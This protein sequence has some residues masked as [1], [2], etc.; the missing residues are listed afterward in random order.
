MSLNVKDMMKPTEIR[1]KGIY[2]FDGLYKLIR[3]WLD[4]RRYDYMEKRYK[5]K[6]STPFGN[7]VEIEMEPELK[8]TEFIK[9]HIYIASHF[10]DVK[11]FEAE[12]DG[13]KKLVTDGKFFMN[14][15]GWI[16]FDYTGKF[17]DKPFSK[18]LLKFLVEKVL[19]RY[20]EFKYYDRL[21]YDVYDLQAQVKK[22]L[23]YETQ[24]NAY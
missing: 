9:F 17:D 4:N 22:F 10:Y 19:R 20:F 5:D 12:I 13:E 11:E 8:V 3:G 21:T 6:V 23:K 16:E 2:D 1:Y 7:E 14:F 24:H 15:N 18:W